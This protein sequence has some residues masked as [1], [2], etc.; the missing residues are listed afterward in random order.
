M[1]C[2][3]C[4]FN[5]VK[6]FIVQAHGFY[7]VV[8]KVDLNIYLRSDSVELAEKFQIDFVLENF[9]FVLEK[10]LNFV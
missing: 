9:L 7:D 1:K 2:F 6:L 10:S 8:I 5:A 3:N 4:L